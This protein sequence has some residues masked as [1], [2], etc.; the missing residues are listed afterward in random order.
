MQSS[1]DNKERFLRVSLLGNLLGYRKI[2][3]ENDT[4]EDVQAA[5]SGNIDLTFNPKLWI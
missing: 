1:T 5:E 2:N 4:Y 3:Y